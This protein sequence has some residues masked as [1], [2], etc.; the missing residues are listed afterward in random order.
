MNI[1]I[2]WSNSYTFIWGTIL[3]CASALIVFP[4]KRKPIHILDYFLFALVLYFAVFVAKAQGI[5]GAA[6]AIILELYGGM[7][8]LAIYFGG[9]LWK[10]VIVNHLTLMASNVLGIGGFL[11]IPGKR[12]TVAGVVTGEGTDLQDGMLFV[13]TLGIATIAVSF[14]AR[15]LARP[16]RIPKREYIYKYCA[17]LILGMQTCMYTGSRV[18]IERM[19]EQSSAPSVATIMFW[20][21]WVALQVLLVNLIAFLYSRMEIWRLQREK[22]W[23]DEII[24]GRYVHYRQVADENRELLTIRNSLT[25][26]SLEELGIGLRKKVE[27]ELALLPLSG[28]LTMDS[29]LFQYYRLAVVEQVVFDAVIEPLPELEIREDE[30]GVILDY[31]L[32]IGLDHCV[33]E[34]KTR[35]LSLS[36]RTRNG[37]LIIKLEGNRAEWDSYEQHRW[38]RMSRIWKGNRRNLHLL[39]KIVERHHGSLVIQ[40]RQGE[41]ML[42][43]FLPKE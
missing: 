42:C 9:S 2:D 36:M 39:E 20:G 43:V 4:F 10:N 12:S 41:G 38:L 7:L 31:A 8:L 26:H 35:W 32:Q 37:M 11:L 6:I 16:E 40:D 21:Y 24:A 15:K 29:L 22:K 5:F 23:L 18:F 25:T 30:L 1:Q 17:L 13:L 19:A 34:D 3:E 28:N 33:Q 14:L 27:E